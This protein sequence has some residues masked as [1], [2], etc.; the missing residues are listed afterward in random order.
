M[1][2]NKNNIK[3]RNIYILYITTFLGGLMFFL[4]IL[5]LYYQQT[6]FSAQNVAFIFAVEAI[7]SAIFEVPTGAVAD[8]FGRKRSMLLAYFIDI[9]AFIIL[10]IGGSMIMFI[11]Y[12]I[13]TALAHA[14]NSGTDTAIMYDT[15]KQEGKENL[16]KKISGIYMAIWPAGAAISSIIG[17]YLATISLRTP[18]FYTIFPFIIALI[19]IFFIDEPKYEK[20]KENTLNGH[21]LESLKDVLRNKQ[22]VLILLGGIV[23]WSFGESTHFL[24]QLFFQFKNIP[25]LWFGY[26][27]AIDFAFSSLGF[28]FSHVISERFGNKRTVVFS[29]ILMSVLLI[30]ATLTTGYIMLALFTVSSFFFGLRSPILGHLWNAECESRKRAT[31][32]SINSLI[33]QLGVALVVPLVGYWSDLFTVNTAFLLSGIIM[34]II[35]S[36]FFAFLKNN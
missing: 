2:F 15:L 11:V 6:L 29:V 30:V 7:A 3:S 22:L 20:K 10:W 25:I 13:L 33:Y 17:G 26:I 27:A 19:L 14:L 4:P 1:E 9:I 28:Y 32:N 12:A 35:P 34:L 8:L 18:V 31:M 24:N 5:A 23:V 21:M 36:I 16:Y